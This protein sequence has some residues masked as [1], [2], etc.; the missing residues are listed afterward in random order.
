MCL[1]G[2]L[3]LLL[4]SVFCTADDFLPEARKYAH[5]R[6]SDAEILTLSIAQ[7]IMDLPSG[8]RFL[9]AARRQ[10]REA[11]PLPADAERAAQA[12]RGTERHLRL[13]RRSQN[14]GRAEGVAVGWL[15]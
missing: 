12:P 6:V 1:D 13:E 7:V 11:L 5:R 4:I 14:P 3:E 10:L 8:R 2:D 15:F 9:P